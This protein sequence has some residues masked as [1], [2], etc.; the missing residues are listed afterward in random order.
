MV[1]KH[2]RSQFPD[3][4]AHWVEQPT[5]MYYGIKEDH[6]N[7]FHFFMDSFA[8]LWHTITDQLGYFNL[9]AF[10]ARCLPC[11]VL[12]HGCIVADAV[13]TV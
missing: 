3:T 8:R 4:C 9:E 10:L 2:N 5:I 11:T 12:H 13:C 1:S 6:Q 7:V